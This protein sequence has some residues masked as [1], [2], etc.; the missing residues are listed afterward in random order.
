MKGYLGLQEV[1]GKAR[2]ASGLALQA[3][4]GACGAC[5]PY[6]AHSAVGQEVDHPCGQQLSAVCADFHAATGLACQLWSHTGHLLSP[7]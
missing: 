3:L 2:D 1:A 7:S 4:R 5:P 6:Q